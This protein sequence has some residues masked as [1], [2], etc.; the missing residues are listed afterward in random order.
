VPSLPSAVFVDFGR[1]FSVCFLFA[2]AWAFLTLRLAALRCLVVA[3]DRSYPGSAEAD[4][5][6]AFEAEGWSGR[7]ETYD[8]VT[9][10]VTRVVAPE[11]LDAAGVR[12]G[13]RVLDVATGPGH[14]A[15][16]AAGRGAT[17]TGIDLAEG[18]LAFARQRH[19]EVEFVAADAEALPFG[20]ASFDAVVAGFVLNHLPSPEAAVAEAVRVLRPGGRLAASVWDAPPRGRLL[21]LLGEAIR[22]AGLAPPPLPPGPDPFRFADDGEFERLLSG[23]GLEGVTVE[24]H[25]IVHAGTEDDD[26]LWEGLLGG[27]VRGSSA[28]LA[29]DPEARQRVREAFGRLML[30]L[31]EG[32]GYAIPAHVKLATGRRP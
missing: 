5:F 3:M 30:E 25:E 17:V 31:R 8:L 2:P 28:V 14:I 12:S 20:D 26:V 32:G 23:C 9:G 19:P 7:A 27:S 11:L 10:T 24:T 18:M 6:K 13:W 22:A 29:L 21:G 4:A 15:A 16:A 1:F